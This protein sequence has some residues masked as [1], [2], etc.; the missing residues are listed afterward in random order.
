MASKFSSI[1]DRNQDKKLD[2]K[3]YNFIF[4]C[5]NSAMKVSLRE[6]RCMNF[7][8]FQR[9]MLTL[10]EHDYDTENKSRDEI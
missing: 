6:W 9:F 1:S 4:I 3:H 2:K 10:Q 8:N 5:R 7:N